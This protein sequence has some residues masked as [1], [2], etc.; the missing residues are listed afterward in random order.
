MFVG[1]DMP[2]EQWNSLFE[3]EP[4]ALLTAEERDEWTK[5]MNKVA[6]ASDAFFPFRDNID[7]AVQ[8]YNNTIIFISI[9][10]L[11]LVLLFLLSLSNYDHCRPV[12]VIESHCLL[13]MSL[14]RSLVRQQNE[15]I[16]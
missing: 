10:Y 8:V 5:T 6:L 7:R 4:P 1:T 11:L 3:G 12:D 13:Q 14:V 16:K 2:L 9:D 15:D